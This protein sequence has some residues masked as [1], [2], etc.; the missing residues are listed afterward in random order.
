MLKNF[1][2]NQIHLQ[3]K[4]VCSKVHNDGPYTKR[5]KRKLKKMDIFE[6]IFFCK[7]SVGKKIPCALLMILFLLCLAAS[8]EEREGN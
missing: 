1:S 5:I 2:I 8:D 7:L 4:I 6:D 3:F